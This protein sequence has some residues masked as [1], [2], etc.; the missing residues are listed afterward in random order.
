MLNPP[1][2]YRF[3]TMCVCMYIY[4]CVCVC[5]YLFTIVYHSWIFPP[6]F[7]YQGFSKWMRIKT[8][9]WKLWVLIYP[10]RKS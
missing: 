7:K 6:L 5:S 4:I 2:T 10:R 1:K 3:C 9:S 8:N